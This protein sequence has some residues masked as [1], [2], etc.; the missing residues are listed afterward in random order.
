MTNTTGPNKLVCLCDSYLKE[1]HT[2]ITSIVSDVKTQMTFE[3]TI[4]YP[5]GGGQPSDQGEILHLSDPNAARASVIAV[6]MDRFNGGDAI[7]ECNIEGEANAFKPGEPVRMILNWDTRFL[8]MRLHSGGHII[9]HAVQYLGL[10]FESVKANHFPAGPSVEFRVTDPS[11]AVDKDALQKLARDLEAKIEEILARNPE[12][13]VY[14][15]AVSEMPEKVRESLPEK[16]KVI[17]GP[18]RLVLFEGCP[19]PVPCGGTHVE[20]AQEIGQVTI[21]KISHKDGILRISYR[22]SP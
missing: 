9:D 5:Q 11:F 4:F 21:K 17:D 18:V 12:I 2:K 8:H 14:E 6:S 13:L 15:Q 3:S 19:L 16:T 20:K 1:H 7:H 22:I 10:P